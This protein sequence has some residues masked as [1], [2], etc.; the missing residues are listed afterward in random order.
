MH[1]DI[2]TYRIAALKIIP[3]IVLIHLQYIFIFENGAHSHLFRFS[4]VLRN[5]CFPMPFIN[6]PLHKLRLFYNSAQLLHKPQA[7]FL[8]T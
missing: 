1:I 3:L 4:C 8:L 6:S 5:V 2:K 7:L